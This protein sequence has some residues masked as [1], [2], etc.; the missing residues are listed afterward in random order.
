ML[1]IERTERYLGTF[2]QDVDS[3]HV[4]ITWF[5]LILLQTPSCIPTVKNPMNISKSF[6]SLAKKKEDEIKWKYFDV[7]YGLE[8]KIVL[9]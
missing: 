9:Y 2:C 7:L 1:T 5:S 4:V 8:T 3:F 6:L